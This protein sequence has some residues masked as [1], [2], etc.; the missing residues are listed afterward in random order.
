MERG[1]PYGSGHA[2]RRPNAGGRFAFVILLKKSGRGVRGAARPRFLR[3][4]ACLRAAALLMARLVAALAQLVEHII[5]NDGVTGSSPVS[6]TS[7]HHIKTLGPNVA[8][9]AIR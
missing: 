2:R 6:G 8:A 5:R 1:F 7:D 9:G 3:D 4:D